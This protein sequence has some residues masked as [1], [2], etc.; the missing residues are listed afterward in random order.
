MIE[1]INASESWRRFKEKTRKINKMGNQCCYEKERK[2]EKL[3]LKEFMED[4]ISYYPGKYQKEDV[5]TNIKDK[6]VEFVTG[7]S[8]N[9]ES[10]WDDKM[11]DFIK[12]YGFDK[13]YQAYK[14][15]VDSGELSKGG[16]ENL[17]RRKYE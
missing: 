4:Y 9:K 11:E 13:V 7:D 1:T 8:N 17:R 6:I 10:D 3:K 15:G 12:K 16:L 5:S 14:N 2:K